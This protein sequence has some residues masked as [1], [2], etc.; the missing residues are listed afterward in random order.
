VGIGG[1]RFIAA[2]EEDATERNPPSINSADHSDEPRHTFGF[3]PDGISLH[4][5][6]FNIH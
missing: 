1:R 4:Q 5:L 2:K 6:S 3:G